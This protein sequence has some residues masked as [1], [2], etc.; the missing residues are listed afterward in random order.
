MQ[1]GTAPNRDR[2]DGPEWVSEPQKGEDAAT[3]ADIRGESGGGGWR[4]DKEE[5]WEGGWVPQ[6]EIC[7]LPH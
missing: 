4:I 3:G 2:P 6:A 1:S 5:C 7:P